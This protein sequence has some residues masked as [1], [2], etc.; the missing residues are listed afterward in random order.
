MLTRDDKIFLF[1]E[2]LLQRFGLVSR[3][4]CRKGVT[5]VPSQC[6]AKQKFVEVYDRQVDTVYRVCYS[7]MKN[8]ADTEDMVQETFLR[9]LST[10]KEFENERHE[11]AWLIVTAS[12]LCKDNL[13][14]WWR[15][16]E[17][18][19]DFLDLAQEPRQDDGVLELILQLPEEYKDAVYMYYYEG[20]TTVEIARHLR[21]PEAT[22]RSRLMRAK[23]KLQVMMGGAAR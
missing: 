5:A 8:R 6:T 13:K 7:F 11:K 19:E 17:N 9:L 15:K 2:K 14:K 4:H 18:I 10:G 16:S 20:Y 1:S 21:C 22:V 23:K 12:N 3:I